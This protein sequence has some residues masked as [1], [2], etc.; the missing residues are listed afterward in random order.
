MTTSEIF[1]KCLPRP[2]STT[3]GVGGMPEITWEDV[4]QGMQ[5]I[6]SGHEGFIRYVYMDD[7]AGRHQFY[8]GL[9]VE[10][11]ARD[12]LVNWRKHHKGH[13]TRLIQL[14][15]EEWVLPA[16]LNTDEARAHEYGVTPNQW[17]RQYKQ[18]YSVIVAAPVYWE[19][20]VL[21]QVRDW[22]K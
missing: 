6:P 8:A 14:A 2:P 21:R 19:D 10:I 16:T 11:C 3:P 20:E 5:W 22:L 15:I 12:D 18:T 17:R 1:S 7:P 9:M 13:T 4:L